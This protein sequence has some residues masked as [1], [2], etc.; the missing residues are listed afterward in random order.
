MEKRCFG[1]TGMEL[2]VLGF[3]ASEIG[4]QHVSPRTVETLL[5]GALDS[6]LNVIDTAA[7]Y[8]NSEELIGRAAGNRRKDYYIFTKCGHAWSGLNLADFS[9][10]LIQRSIERSLKRLRT[11]YL[12]L[13]ELHSCEEETLRRGEAVE[14]L[15]RARE[16]GKTRFIGYSGDGGAALYAVESGAFDALQISINIADQ[17][18]IDRVMPA[19]RERDIGVIAKRPIA[20]AV[21]M[22]GRRRPSDSYVWTYWERLRTLDYD[23]LRAGAPAAVAAALRFTLSVPG[24]HTAIIGTTKPARWQENAALAAAG[25]LPAA[26]YEAVRARWREVAK[27]DWRGQ[28]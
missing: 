1:R 14:A 4:E 6:G 5:Q 18:A 7:C 3:G 24:V 11:D 27:R 20:N 19:A 22:S 2:S 28:R 13:V 25:A 17:E 10:A 12:D 15:I 9:P 26:D 16:A 23:F 21:W 8:E